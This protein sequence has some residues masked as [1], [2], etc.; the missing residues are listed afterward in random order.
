MNYSR[1]CVPHACTLRAWDL[2][3]VHTSMYGSSEPTWCLYSWPKFSDLG[4]TQTTFNWRKR[5]GRFDIWVPV[6]RVPQA[7]RPIMSPGP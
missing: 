2:M 1:F 3:D 4:R 5:H 7:R 6:L